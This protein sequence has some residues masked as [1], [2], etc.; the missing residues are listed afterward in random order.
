M[1]TFTID[2]LEKIINDA[3]TIGLTGES[4]IYISACDNDETFSMIKNV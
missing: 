2:G 3:K 4:E 1:T